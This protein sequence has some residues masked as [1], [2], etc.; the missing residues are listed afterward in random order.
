MVQVQPAVTG[1]DKGRVI[2]RLAVVPLRPVAG[3]G[4]TPSL[5]TLQRQ[6]TVAGL[7]CAGTLD[8]AAS[9]PALAPGAIALLAIDH[10]CVLSGETRTGAC[11]SHAPVPGCRVRGR[12]PIATRRRVGPR[13]DR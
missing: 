11:V 10:A 5:V 6:P 8:H 2:P 9:C 13:R 7:K 3:S 12:A 4:V 1:T